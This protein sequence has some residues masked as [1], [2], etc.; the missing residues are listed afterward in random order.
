[1]RSVTKI[2]LAAL[3]LCLLTACSGLRLAYDNA[4]TY[5]RWRAGNYLDVHGEAA[6]DLDER[7]DAFLGWHRAKA[8][9]DYAKL[10][11]EAARRL[12]DGLSRQD[13]VWGYDSVRAHVARSLTEAAQRIAPLLDRLSEEQVKH[14]ES[15]F[16]EDNR[17]FARENLRGSEKERRKR[18]A[19][20]VVDR[21]EDWVGKLSEAQEQRVREFSERAPL[22][23]EMRD[24]DRRRVQSE[25]VGMVRSRAAQKHLPELAAHWER[26]RDPAFVAANQAWREEFFSLLLDV[27]RTLTPE[28]RARAQ[29]NFRRYSED[30]AVLSSRAAP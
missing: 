4:D 30:F 11:D 3:C 26:G 17:K 2:T 7:I 20:R 5:L 18:R 8:L 13:V 15:R 21:L 9:P 22:A 27:D 25:F 28:Q 6:D 23:A 12:G 14:I 29:G 1:V 24:K 19:D 16:A 10:T